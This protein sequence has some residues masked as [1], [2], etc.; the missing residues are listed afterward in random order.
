VSPFLEN[1]ALDALFDQHGRDVFNVSLRVTG[2]RD[3][4]AAATSAAFLEMPPGDG[5]RVA[6]LAAARRESG[7]PA[8]SSGLADEPSGGI[9]EANARL[10]VRHREVLAL[11][12]LA[13]CSYQEIA[14]IVGTDRETVAELLWQARLALRDELEGSALL[15]IAP[16]ATSCKRALGLIVM[17][18]DGELHED[19]DRIWLQRH[20]RNCGKCRLSQESV[21]QASAYYRAWPTATPLGIT[22]PAERPAAVSET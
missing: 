12:E 10:D 17:S 2:S 8:V 13:G 20:L 6:L 4:A 1:P 5:N 22:E 21:R 7:D 18:W 11:R 9:G 15:S 16:L 19:D 3:A 14:Q